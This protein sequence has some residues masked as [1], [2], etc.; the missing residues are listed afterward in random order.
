MVIERAHLHA[1]F[2]ATYLLFNTFSLSS[3]MK[4]NFDQFLIV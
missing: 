2:C 4:C 3:I 1:L